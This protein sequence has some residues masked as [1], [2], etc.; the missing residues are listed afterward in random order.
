MTIR[1]DGEVY[2]SAEA[3]CTRWGHTIRLKTLKN[4]RNV[5]RGP[6]HVKFGRLVYY[7]MRE[8]EAFEIKDMIPR[9]KRSLRMR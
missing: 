5:N 3:L 4:W 8:I 6:K 2:L 1:L 7:P 9:P